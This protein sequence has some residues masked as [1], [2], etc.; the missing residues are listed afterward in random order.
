VAGF[1][2]SFEHLPVTG[3]K[4]LAS[5]CHNSSSTGESAEDQ[6]AEMSISAA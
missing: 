2:D 3:N 4:G 1:G 6:A 5:E